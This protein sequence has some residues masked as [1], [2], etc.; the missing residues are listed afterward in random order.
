MTASSSVND[1]RPSTHCVVWQ[2]TTG[3]IHLSEPQCALLWAQ[4]HL[5]SFFYQHP[6]R[7]C[8]FVWS[9]G[10]DNSVL[11]KG[12]GTQIAVNEISSQT[13]CASPRANNHS[14]PN[15]NYAPSRH[16][17]CQ[18]P[19]TILSTIL[20]ASLLSLSRQ[21]L[22]RLQQLD[23]RRL[24][25]ALNEFSVLV[26]TQYVLVMCTAVSWSVRWL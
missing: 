13:A 9:Q 16:A 24:T 20:L 26:T 8:T 4:R 18:A 3:L 1:H 22:S 15:S 6:G 14:P 7:F 19:G 11:R 25:S 5:L 17:L 12:Q 10:W 2:P 23:A 21:R